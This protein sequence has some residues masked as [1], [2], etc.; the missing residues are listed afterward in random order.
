LR[1][2]ALTSLR[3][4]EAALLEACKALVVSPIAFE[5]PRITWLTMQ[6]E[7]R[8]LEAAKAAIADA[9]PPEVPAETK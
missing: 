4:S 8:D 5:D 2:A 1:V 9:D 7:R 3:D 6:V